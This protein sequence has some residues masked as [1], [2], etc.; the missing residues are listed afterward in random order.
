MKR[1]PKCK[2]LKSENDFY[3]NS[4]MKDGLSIHCKKCHNQNIYQSTKNHKIKIKQE[5]I[6]KELDDFNYSLGGHK[7]II[8]NYA[9]KSEYKYIINSTS[10]ETFKSNDKLQ[11]IHK[12]KELIY[13]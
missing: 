7:I 8:L 5:E 9:K 6:Q 10:G 11:F 4:Y 1:C 3:K 2:E 12:I 13:R